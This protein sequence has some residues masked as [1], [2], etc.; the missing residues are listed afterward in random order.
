MPKWKNTQYIPWLILQEAFKRDELLGRINE[1]AIFVPF[2]VSELRQLVTQQLEQVR[3]RAAQIHGIT[4]SWN[5]EV[6]NYLAG[7]FNETYGARNMKY[8]V[9]ATPT[10][11][12]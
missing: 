9:G 3:K 10:T 2:S 12:M 8:E 7:T 11:E 4:L 5:D 6:L 1:V